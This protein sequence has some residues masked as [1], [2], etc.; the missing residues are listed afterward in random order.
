MIR[1]WRGP[2]M[3]VVVIAALL[4]VLRVQ[5]RAPDAGVAA[6]NRQGFSGDRAFE[7]LGSL[8]EDNVPHPA[9][10]AANRV[11]ADRIVARLRAAGYQPEIQQGFKCSTL[12]P[13]CSVVRNII[14]VR[15][16]RD[17]REAVLVTA[18]YD[19]VPGSVAAADDGAG[20]AAM[21][22]IAELIAARGP[23]LHDVVFLFADAEETGLRGAMLFADAHPLMRR[24][25]FVLN[26]EARGVTGPGMM[27]ETG[28]DNRALVAAY[29]RAVPRPVANSL[30]YEVYRHMPN[31]TDFTIYKRRGASGLNFA[32][33]RGAALYHSERDDLAHLDRRSLQHQ[34]E[35]VFATLLRIADTPVGDLAAAGDATYFDIGGR[36]LPRWPAAWNAPLA[37]LGLL[38]VLLASL[39][40]VPRADG[41]SIAGSLAAL[42]LLIVLVVSFGWLLS[43]PLGKWPGVHPL[44]HP[45]PWPGRIALIAAS[46]LAPLVVV[47]LLARRVTVG[48]MS[49]VVWVVMGLLALAVSLTVPGAS[50]VF[51]VPLLVYGVLAVIEAFAMRSGHNLTWVAAPAAFVAASYLALYHFLQLDVMFNFDVAQAKVI[52]LLL[53]TLPLLPI[54]LAHVQRHGSRALIGAGSALVVGAAAVAMA[55]PT[56]TVDRPRGVNLLYV[57]D[58]AHASAQWQIQSFGEPGRALL[59]AM[60]FDAV[61]RPVLRLGVAPTDVYL[62]PATDRALATPV[63]EI[64]EDFERDGQRIVRGRVQSRRPTFQ[65]GL[66]FAAHSPVLGL[67]IEGQPVLAGADD[68]PRIVGVHGVGGDPVA[69]E[70]IAT[71]R[72]ALSVVAFDIGPLMADREGDAMLA[73][74]PAD[75]APLHAGNQSIV[76]HHLSLATEKT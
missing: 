31:N 42:A 44:D 39:R 36:V 43:W 62:K 6:T 51:I 69:F 23:L 27:F 12:A 61:K 59:D 16:G 57:Q 24:V 70:L 37:G 49:S 50:F 48:A 63:V 40:H 32:F 5:D 4:A 14:A 13:G 65:L 29:A 10:S 25:A 7:I 9:G 22:E 58:D 47:A 74:R 3:L 21:L 34:G 38:L 30:L 17:A 26:M 75:A 67:R 19:S 64:D 33:S 66:A 53:L 11:I 55:V 28:A 2:V 35:S 60:G 20:V 46:V 71:P 72:A 68:A 56:H 8:L 18:H 41:R 54:A 15:E 1:R 73:R 52:P 76:L 45:H